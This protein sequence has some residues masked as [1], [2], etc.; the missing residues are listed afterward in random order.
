M[1]V[2]YIIVPLA[3]AFAGVAV[4]AFIWSV[5]SDQYEDLIGPAHKMLLDDEE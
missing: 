2:L 5:R 1:E 4:I 3:L